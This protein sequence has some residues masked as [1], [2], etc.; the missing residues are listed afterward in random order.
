VAGIAQIE[1]GAAED[2][3]VVTD[4]VFTECWGIVSRVLRNPI[5]V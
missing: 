2:F 5:E 4:E 3:L 1:D